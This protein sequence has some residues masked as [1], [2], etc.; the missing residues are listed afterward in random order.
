MVLPFLKVL[1]RA[2]LHGGEDRPRPPVP[3]RE[4]ADDRRPNENEL[5]ELARTRRNEPKGNNVR[6]EAATV[7]VDG[8]AMLVTPPAERAC[9]L[10]V[11]EQPAVND[12]RHEGLPRHGSPAESDAKNLDVAFD[13]RTPGLHQA[14]RGNR[15]RNA[16]KVRRVHVKGEELRG[17]HGE[18]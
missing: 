5:E 11:F 12:A 14:E 17:W 9:K 16:R 8:H 6:E 4:H 15:R 1:V 10:D 18:R 7:A 13:G 3:P 2:I